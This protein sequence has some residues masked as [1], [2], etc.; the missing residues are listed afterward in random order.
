[1]RDHL[2]AVERRLRE[3]AGVMADGRAAEGHGA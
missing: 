1:M 3:R 2:D